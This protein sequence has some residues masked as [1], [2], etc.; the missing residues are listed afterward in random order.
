[1]RLILA[2]VFVYASI[3]GMASVLGA[4][5]KC[6]WPSWAAFA[7]A[8]ALL[9]SLPLAM[10]LFNHKTGRWRRLSPEE[11]L[12]ELDVSGLVERLSFQAR[13]A[14]AVEEYED[15]GLH[16]FIELSDERVLYLEGQYLLDYTAIDDDPDVNQ[17]R[18][19]PC[20]E[21]EILRHRGEGYVLDIVCSGSVLEPEMTTAAFTKQEL[22]R[23][24]PQDGQIITDRS[25]DSL[26]NERA[27]MN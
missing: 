26:K 11:H 6:Q 27:M 20:T 23:G 3:I 4:H 9:V 12:A 5:F 10:A 24:I 18:T 1:M 14:F 21:F 15:E 2:A 13:R 7:S 19:F 22:R 16:Y 25:Y 8:G 17:P